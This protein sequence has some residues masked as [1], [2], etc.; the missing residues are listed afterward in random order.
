MVTGKKFDRIAWSVTVVMIAVTILFM[1]GTSIGLEV[2]SKG[3]GYEE[4]IFD[5]TR[6]HTIDIVMN[7][8]D[9]FIANASSETYTAANVVIDGEVFK[10]VGIRGKGNT[11]LSNVASM[12]SQR[13]SLKIEF[14]HYDKSKTY[15]G[16]DKLALN[17]LIQDST[18]MKDYLAYTMMNE[19]GVNAPLC[20]FVYVT[21]NGEDWG[22]FLAVEAVE[23][24]FLRRNYGTDY[25]ELYKPDST[26]FGGGRGNGRDFRMSEFWKENFESDDSETEESA[27]SN[28]QD[29]KQSFQPEGFDPSQMNAGSMPQPFGEGGFDPAQMGDGSAPQFPG[30]FT[31]P[32][33][34]GEFNPDS[35]QRS[36][37]APGG[38]PGGFG[39]GSS[40]VKL[41]YTD[42]DPDSYSNI[43]ENAKT[44][45]STA[46]QA[47]LI[48]SLEKLGNNEDIESVVDI[49]QVIRYFVVHNYVCN[50]DS[51]TGA[52]IHNYYLYEKDGQLA[53]IPW[54]Y[55]LAYGTF[56]GSDADSTVNTPIDSPVSGSIEDRPMLNWI[57]ANDEYTEL[58]HQYFAEFLSSVDI[59]GIIG[60]A[61]ELIAPYVKKDP[62]AFF[63][64]EEFEKGAAT[65]RT[66]C[67]LRTESI[68][69]QLETG[70]T[71]N[72]MN[73]ADASGITIS[74]MGSMGG[75]G[76]GGPQMPGGGR[77]D[78]SE[79]RNP[80]FPENAD[81]KSGRPQRPEKTEGSE[82]P[83]PVQPTEDSPA[84]AET[85][86]DLPETGMDASEQTDNRTADPGQ[87]QERN[88]GFGGSGQE[89]R[90]P[91]S[92]PGG[93]PGNFPG[94]FQQGSS[95]NGTK[96]VMIWLGV[97]ALI[98]AAGLLVAKKYK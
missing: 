95:G 9:S 53:M 20:S 50:G 7:D 94:E 22:L 72:T 27:A 51:Y 63:T 12:N 93:M 45:I 86:S 68:Q 37:R 32:D 57:F 5:N 91:M 73:Y 98:L 49:D 48:R 17:N 38:G 61:Y 3:M 4:R 42:D 88:P 66:F 52:M 30:E 35:E 80:G 79:S 54:D 83:T 74:D 41:Q 21:V 84:E 44:D 67:E 70:E 75:G 10:S 28:P 40:D 2:L 43:W 58:Y 97:S 96:T 26:G 23:D 64:Y 76:G 19:F 78:G 46:D 13:Y 77:P 14:D 56:Q 55:N 92:F 34:P 81:G 71:V 1:N 85:G 8:W 39:M 11:S 24:A 60:A 90:E 15:Y 65:L 59:T 6:V 36:G 31:P 89:N 16:L 82:F 87:M 69:K 25:G 29:P 18:M 62:T 33:M 47:R